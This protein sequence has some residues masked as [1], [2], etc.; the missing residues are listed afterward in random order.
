MAPYG[1]LFF[2]QK[3][4][5]LMPLTNLQTIDSPA[6]LAFTNGNTDLLLFCLFL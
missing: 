3:K 5:G 2:W 1:A 6:V 4:E